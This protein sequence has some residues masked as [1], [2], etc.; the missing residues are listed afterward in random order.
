M[1]FATSKQT[2][3]NQALKF[4]FHFAAYKAVPNLIKSFPSPEPAPLESVSCGLFWVLRVPG[5][6]VQIVTVN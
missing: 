3:G 2:E 6:L 5:Q 1:L 4:P